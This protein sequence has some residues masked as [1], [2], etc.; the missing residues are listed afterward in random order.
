MIIT[1][2][3]PSSTGKTTLVESLKPYSGILSSLSGKSVVFV[4]ES[5]RE[6][7]EKEYSGKPLQEIFQ[8]AEES[9]RVQFSVTDLN[10]QRYSDMLAHPE[11]LY[12]C[13]RGALDN[14]VYTLLRYISSPPEIM[15]KYA[16]RFSSCCASNRMLAGLEDIAFITKPDY[17]SGLPEDDGYRPEMFSLMRK[18]ENE[19]FSAAFRSGNVMCLPSDTHER[20]VAVMQAV[21]RLGKAGNRN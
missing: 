8:D 4:P 1:V 9:M 10:L 20:C 21:R 13:D 15:A 18:A 12:I 2:S 16:A 5:I 17:L 7:T 14:L 6:V 3:G 11:N 19:L